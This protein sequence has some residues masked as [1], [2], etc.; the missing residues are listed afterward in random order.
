MTVDVNVIALCPAAEVHAV[1]LALGLVF[2]VNVN[3]IVCR[4]LQLRK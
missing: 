2:A 4:W 3:H 1:D